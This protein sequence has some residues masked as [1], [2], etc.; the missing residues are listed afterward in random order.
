MRTVEL[1]KIKNKYML[2]IPDSFV[3]L[4]SVKVGQSFNLEINES[5]NAHKIIILTYATEMN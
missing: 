2:P 4:Y 5:K 1:I 3:N